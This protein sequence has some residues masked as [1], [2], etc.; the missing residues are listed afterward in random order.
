M[1]SN[2]S[3]KHRPGSIVSAKYGRLHPV[4]R[5]DKSP[6]RSRR[7]RERIRGVLLG[8][9][10]DSEWFVHWFGIERTASAPSTKLRV[11]QGMKPFP[12]Y[13]VESLRKD[14]KELY[15]GNSDCLRNY[16]D[17]LNQTDDRKRP[18]VTPAKV[19][20]EQAKRAKKNA[21]TS[22]TQTSSATSSATSAIAAVNI[23]ERVNRAAAERINRE[24]EEEESADE[25]QTVGE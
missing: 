5:S 22:T 6:E 21:P 19:T 11:E 25:L 24:G 9:K 18:A 20:P 2:S 13:Q 7:T 15:I 4:E 10:S 14:H 1:S 16:I 8:P 3:G 12:G 17:N 23:Y